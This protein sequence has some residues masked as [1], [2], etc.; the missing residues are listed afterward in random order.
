MVSIVVSDFMVVPYYAVGVVVNT[1]I[2]DHITKLTT[3]QC[4]GQFSDQYNALFIIQL[5][6]FFIGKA[7]LL[8]IKINN[9]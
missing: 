2:T 9:G 8:S 6:C 4:R 3:C 7:S 1:V 5:G